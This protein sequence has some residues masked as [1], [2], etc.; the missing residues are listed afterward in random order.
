MLTGDRLGNWP[1]NKSDSSTSSISKFLPVDV[2]P[3]I[4]LWD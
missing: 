1:T 2:L 4:L 3:I